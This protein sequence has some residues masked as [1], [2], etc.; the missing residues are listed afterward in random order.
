LAEEESISI[1]QFRPIDR[2]KVVA[3]P[4]SPCCDSIDVIRLSRRPKE[5]S[6]SGSPGRAVVLENKRD[7]SSITWDS[8][9]DKSLSSGPSSSNQQKNERNISKFGFETHDQKINLVI[10]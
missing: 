3:G 1:G 8:S 4:G 9:S 7:A 6:I 10:S 2:N 5:V